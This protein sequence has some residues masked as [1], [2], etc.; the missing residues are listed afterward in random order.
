MA[1]VHDLYKAQLLRSRAQFLGS[2][3][4]FKG[5]ISARLNFLAGDLTGRIETL[6]KGGIIP[7][8]K[9]KDIEEEIRAV[10]PETTKG[11]SSLLDNQIRVSIGQAAR[12][13]QKAAGVFSYY[14]KA[15]AKEGGVLKIPE[16]NVAFGGGMANFTEE[17]VSQV[18]DKRWE[19]GRKLSQRIWNFNR[20][21]EKDLLR[22]VKSGVD[23][24]EAAR[25]ISKGLR[26]YLT[27]EGKGSPVYRSMRIART[28]TNEAYK[29]AHQEISKRQTFVKGTKWNL[30]ASHK[31]T[32]ICDDYAEG[33]SHGNGV[34]PVGEVPGTPH[35]LC[36]CF[37]T[38]ELPTVEE[39]LARPV[40]LPERPTDIMTELA[41]G[42]IIEEHG[43]IGGINAPHC[44]R[45]ASGRQAIVKKTA[46]WAS[47]ATDS[48]KNEAFAYRFSKKYG[49]NIVPETAMRGTSS[50][51]R[52]IPNAVR[53]DESS[54]VR[55]NVRLQKMRAMDAILGNLD[56]HGGNVI[57]DKAG[58]LWAID[59]G[60]IDYVWR[61]DASRQF[62]GLVEQGVLDRGKWGPVSELIGKVADSSV[63]DIF[64]TGGGLITREK[65]KRIKVNAQIAVEKIME[66]I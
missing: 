44:V 56:R 9:L 25:K 30:S 5:D 55:T 48:A 4:E 8:D 14:V 46:N 28:E 52:W 22:K 63:E 24:G 57:V 18:W 62:K 3:T 29:L 20:I 17:L 53:L 41:E 43:G 42:R 34:Y 51:Q 7:V 59:N 2:L 50:A 11:I 37:L 38:D 61:G 10:V 23:E 16:I 31:K 35:P 12:G 47:I 65:A 54:I 36:L 40:E 26:R 6:E 19:D 27:G 49:F 1:A 64:K 15:A 21:T 32:D 66:R 33:G 39:F 45:F 60:F 58:R 13:K